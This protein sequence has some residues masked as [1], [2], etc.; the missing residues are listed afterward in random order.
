[1]NKQRLIW[2][3]GGALLIVV[4]FII[5]QQLM[6][7]FASASP[8]SEKEVQE[9][10]QER[11]PVD[12]IQQ[13]SLNGT[14]YTIQFL[15]RTGLYEVKVDAE[16]SE[17]TALTLLEENDASSQPEGRADTKED[18]KKEEYLT[19][20]AISDIVN[21]QISG[22]AKVELVTGQD[23]HV[24][25]AVVQGDNETTTL[26]INAADGT[27]LTTLVE[28]SPEPLP[29]TPRVLTEE[30][31]V[32]IALNRVNGEVEGVDFEP[33]EEG[34]YYLVEIETLDEQ[35][36]IVQINA[37]S[38]EIKSLTWDEDGDDDID[39]DQDN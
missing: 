36:V 9:T 19:E 39:D 10:I 30:E 16:S 23:P 13:L 35:E 18:V 2:M 8:L 7:G 11:Y 20:Q 32:N 33:L 15:S 6:T 14:T 22:E 26:T 38:G 12:E 37:I 31:A 28:K 24:Y 25:K 5:V 17:I 29:E 27:I 4:L 21:Q 34:S 1:M 3:G